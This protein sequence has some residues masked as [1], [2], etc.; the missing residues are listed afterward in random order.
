MTTE[1]QNRLIAEFMGIKW[2]SARY[3]KSWDCLMPVVEKIENTF[4]KGTGEYCKVYISS[5]NDPKD[6]FY[7][8]NIFGSEDH[9]FNGESKDSKILSVCQAVSEFLKWYNLTR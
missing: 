7:Y 2:T 3:D 6:M 4:Q 8:C 5:H 1:E 9:E